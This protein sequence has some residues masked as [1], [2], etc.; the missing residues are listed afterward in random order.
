MKLAAINEE[1]RLAVKEAFIHAYNGYEK[2]ACL[3]A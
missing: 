3:Q 1:R 2:Y